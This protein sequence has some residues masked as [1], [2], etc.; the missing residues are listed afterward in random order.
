MVSGCSTSKS[1]TID[2]NTTPPNAVITS[3]GDVLNCNISTITLN[4]N[5]S[6]GQGGIS[7]LWSTGSIANSITVS[8]PGVYSLTVTDPANGCTDTDEITVS[9]N[10]NP[11]TANITKSSVEFTC[12]TT[13]MVL[14]AETSFGQGGLLSY[15]WSTGESTPQIIITSPGTYSV[16]VKD[17][18][19]GCTDSNT[20]VVGEN[21]E[22]PV[23]V[24]TKSHEELTCDTTSIVLDAGTS[25][26]QGK[27]SY[28]WSTGDT[29]RT[30]EVSAPGSYSVTVKDGRNGCTDEA[31]VEIQENIVPPEIGISETHTELTCDTT[32]I[33]LTAVTSDEE[34]GTLKY[35][36]STGAK[37]SSITVTDPGTYSVTATSKLNGCSA[38]ASIT[39]GQNTI[40]PVADI[41]KSRVRLTCDTTS[42]ILSGANSSGQGDLSYHWSTGETTR[43]IE[44]TDP[45]IYQLTV[46]D[47]RNGCSN[48]A[49]IQIMHDV[50]TPYVSIIQ[51]ETTTLT[52]ATQEIL[53]DASDAVDNSGNDNLL[54]SWS[55]G[56]ETTSGITVTDP[57]TYTVTVKDSDNGCT[58]SDSIEI[59]QDIN[60]TVA[61]IAQPETTE[62]TCSNPVITL[63][64]SV[65]TD[66]SGED[67]LTYLWSPGGETTSQIEVSEPGKYSVTV[68]DP[69]NGCTSSTSITITQDI[70]TP[71]ADI[72]ASSTLLTCSNTDITLDA[73]ASEDNSGEKNLA[74][75]WSPGGET[76]SSITVTNPGTYT[77]TVTDPDNGCSNV[78]EMI[79]TQDIN[80]PVALIDEPATNVLTCAVTSINLNAS[81]SADNSGESNLEYS[82]S[83]GETT[84]G[85]SVSEPGT[86]TVTVTDPDNG[87]SDQAS[88]EISQDINAPVAAIAQPEVTVLTCATTEITLNAAGSSDNSGENNLSYSWSNGDKTAAITVSTPGTYTVTV[89]DP[90]NGCSDQASIEITQDT[91]APLASIADPATTVLSCKVDG[92]I[93]DASGSTDNSGENNLQY[94]WSDGESTASITVSTPGMYTVTVTDPDNGCSGEASIEITQDL[95]PPT[96]TIAEPDSKILTCNVTEIGLDASASI[97]N[98]GQANLEYSWSGGENTASITVTAPGTYVVTVTDPDNGCSAKDSM[99]ITENQE[100]TASV[101]LNSPPECFGSADAS[102]TVNAEGGGGEFTY[103]WD[104][105]ET[106]AT[107][108]AL[109]AG[110]HT[111]T[112]TDQFGC[113]ATGTVSID[114]PDELIAIAES[115]SPV[116]SGDDIM[117]SETSGKAIS[118]SWSGPDNFTSNLQNPVISDAGVQNNGTY[119]VIISN[120][121]CVDTAIIVVTVNQKPEAVDDDYTVV[122]NEGFNGNVTDNDVIDGGSSV[123]VSVVPGSE[124]EHGVLTMNPD[125]EF[126]YV[127]D[128]TYVG[129]DHF[130]YTECSDAGCCDTAVV[131]LNVESPP[132]TP[133]PIANNDT[134]S[135]DCSELTGQNVLTNDV[136][137]IAVNVNLISDVTHGT[138]TLNPDGTFDYIPP[139]DGYIG[140]DSFTYQLCYVDEP[141]N[142]SA[143]GVVTIHVNCPPCEP[144]VPNGFSP[145][146]DGINDF[147]EVTCLDKYPN[148]HLMV[149][150]RWGDM[151]YEQE[152][153]GNPD[154][155]SGTARWWDGRPSSKWSIGKEILPAGTYVY[156]LILEKGGKVMKGTVFLNK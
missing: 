134:Y 132:P 129:I 19:N 99:E 124:P 122:N 107:A 56:G 140:D 90:D 91:N 77:V 18:V 104:N 127:P 128:N 32:K 84:S 25:A 74:Y 131:T 142:C 103:L 133:A 24:I 2:Q 147:F 59:L 151:V 86:Y 50:N 116:C 81:G 47:S 29:T 36:W 149:F 153:Y 11:P 13:E 139:V 79:V 5:T 65:S 16:T 110:T 154:A 135:T 17:P 95:N 62:L 48:T 54:F 51:P 89:T 143:N 130:T 66:N 138:L 57:G 88:V 70:N 41:Q 118:W 39:V 68:T 111:V 82:W 44:I 40:P 4:G 23:A 83:D 34:A 58:Y 22:E 14:S 100:I 52:C 31:S 27:L 55:P 102:A 114:Q 71:V 93:L 136:Y 87:C 63:D 20:I 73:S 38:D 49:L 120:G 6:T 123:T 125:G 75:S 101:T 126:S 98:S 67:N 30:I 85:I 12:D 43:D 28:E 53:L 3:S 97:D 1:V 109:D 150:N 64:A 35:S 33:V 105:G 78:A 92:I 113:T 144:F 26:G 8:G 9:Q 106:T 42:M 146:G 108:T 141:N 69:D 15:M 156:I 117:L 115:N 148:A 60:A 152:N 119:S 37:T 112:V 80:A 121:T 10:S 137:T 94:S 21:I 7:Y 46:T 145:N 155:W 61:R 76:T 72:Q 96:A 45:G